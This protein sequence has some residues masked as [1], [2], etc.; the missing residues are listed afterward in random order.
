MLYKKSAVHLILVLLLSFSLLCPPSST[1]NT[2]PERN[3]V[4]HRNLSGVK[5]P[6]CPPRDLFC[7]AKGNVAPPRDHGMD[8]PLAVMAHVEDQ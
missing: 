6:P 4:I 3:E 2:Q 7:H 8:D 1:T 5:P